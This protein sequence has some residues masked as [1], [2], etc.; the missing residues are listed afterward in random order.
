MIF[1]A[2][3]RRYTAKRRRGVAAVEFALVA[4]VMILLV[5][6]MM[7]VGRAL[8]V[9]H[10]LTNA[11]RDGARAATLDGSTADDVESQVA[12]Y[13]ADS[14]VRGATVTVAPN[15]LD[16]AGSGDPVTVTARV[17]FDSVSWLPSSWY[18][19]GATLQAAVVMRRETE[20][21]SP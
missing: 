13:L 8:M 11:A 19:G 9:Q 12:Q 16:S 7:D 2:L 4:P 14:S 18:L 1:A 21:A 15:P 10:L 20:S 17:S 3:Q 6:G 5:F